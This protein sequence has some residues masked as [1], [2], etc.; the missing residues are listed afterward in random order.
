MNSSLTLS[1][2]RQVTS[3]IEPGKVPKYR[4]PHIPLERFQDAAT[5]A[6]VLSPDLGFC[7]ITAP[8]VHLTFVQKHEVKQPLVAR[9]IVSPLEFESN[10]IVRVYP[11]TGRHYPMRVVTRSAALFK[12]TPVRI[13]SEETE[14]TD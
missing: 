6:A 2:E 3:S 1:E 12:P 8:G 9:P 7:F 10:P 13:I 11:T 5:T 14:S 4:V